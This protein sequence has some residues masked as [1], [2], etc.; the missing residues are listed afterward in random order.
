MLEENMM[1]FFYNQ[2]I[3]KT[4]LTLNSISRC[5]KGKDQ[6]LKY[7]KQHFHIAKDIISKMK[8]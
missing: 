4:F 2:E 5:N 6:N 8:R 1:K 3:G 7:T